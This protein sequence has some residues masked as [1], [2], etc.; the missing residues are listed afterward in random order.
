VVYPLRRYS[1]GITPS[2]GIK[3]KCPPVANE[4]LTYTATTWKWCKIG[5]KLVLITNRKS[6]IGFRLV[7][8]SVTLNDFERRN[9][10]VVCV[11][12]PNLIACGAYYVKV[13][14]DTPTHS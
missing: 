5:G 14:E 4:N 6:H 10:R 9:G 8:K 12:S 7:P 13:V 11:I 3:V 1:Q 2:D